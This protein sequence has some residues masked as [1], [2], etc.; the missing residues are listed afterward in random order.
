M[1]NTN[2]ALNRTV[3]IVTGIVL[4]ALGAGA[5][6]VALLPDVRSAWGDTA[7]GVFDTVTGWF[8]A[9]PMV[10]TGNSW[11]WVGIIA[12]LVLAVVAA[13]VFM[14]RQ[15]H[16]H[17]GTLL[18]DDPTD[19]GT[20]TIDTKVA[21][22]AVQEA[23]ENRP[24]LLST[25]VSTYSVRGTPM[26]KVSVTARRGVSPREVTTMVDEVLHNLD[27]LLGAEIP[28]LVHISGGFRA[29]TKAAARV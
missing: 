28:A 15:G 22:D 8:R 9:T 11:I 14:L 13:I 20:T 1:N 23:L 21:E 4:M 10:D 12:A 27:A 7:P 6:A 25:R 24:E 26:L 17:T 19:H 18:T 5:I 16:G 29:R 2:R 3:V